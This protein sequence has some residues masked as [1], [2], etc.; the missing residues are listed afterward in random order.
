MLE[1]TPSALT[2]QPHEYTV[3][4][5]L[6]TLKTSYKSHF[7]SKWPSK[8]R[9]GVLTD[10]ESKMRVPQMISSYISTGLDIFKAHWKCTL[11]DWIYCVRVRV[12]TC[13]LNA[14]QVI[15]IK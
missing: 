2:T 13:V 14:E 6:S 8:N 7:P 3:A 15:E 10:S 9:R 1:A 4:T 12:F 5:R 11:R